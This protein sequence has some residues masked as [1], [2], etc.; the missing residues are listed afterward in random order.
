[1][2][3]LT[4]K[5]PS[6][7]QGKGRRASL[8]T[9]GRGGQKYS[10]STARF[11][12]NLQSDCCWHLLLQCIVLD[13]AGVCFS[14]RAVRTELKIYTCFSEQQWNQNKDKPGVKEKPLGEWQPCFCWR[15]CLS[16]SNDTEQ[17]LSTTGWRRPEHCF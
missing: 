15:D 16:P 10:F 9:L 1:M 7:G 4:L 13:M 5:P 6:N 14:W 3:S 8:R 11:L 2:N 12:G 17:R